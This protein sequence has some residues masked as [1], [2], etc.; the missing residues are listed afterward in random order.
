M[1]SSLDSNLTAYILAPMLEHSEVFALMR[2]CKQ[3][4]RDLRGSKR[5]HQLYEGWVLCV[6]MEAE[7]AKG[8]NLKVLKA[9][10]PNRLDL[11]ER[12][13][14]DYLIANIVELD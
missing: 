11:F 14:L 2:V 8:Y 3:F 5:V 9:S 6:Q 4:H 12:I 1:Q 13:Q 7:A 10:F